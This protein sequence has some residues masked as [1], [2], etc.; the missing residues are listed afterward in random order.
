MA[1]SGQSRIEEQVVVFTL[2]D[3]VY[4]MDIGSVLEIIRMESV[5]RVPGTPDFIEGII[6]LRGKV[7]PVMD[8]CRRFNM[9]PSKISD[10]TRVI[11]AEA[12]G[13]TVG[14]IV[15]S[16]SEVLRIPASSIEPPPAIIAGSSIEALRG[17]ALVDEKMIILLDLGKVLYEEEKRQLEGFGK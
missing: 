6:N 12:G 16:V 4:G 7:I 17:I 8:L 11:I 13:V 14:M 5:T 2:R 1:V 15:D 10:S 3:Q 9:P